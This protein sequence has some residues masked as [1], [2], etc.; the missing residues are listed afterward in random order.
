MKK[1]NHK[2]KPALSRRKQVQIVEV[3]LR[4]GLQNEATVVSVA[5]RVKLAAELTAAGVSRMELGA[6]VRSDR[7]PQMAGSLEVIQK[8]LAKMPADKVSGLAA[9]VPN[10]KGM[11]DAVKSGIREVSIFT[12]ASESFTKANTNCT[13]EESFAR[14]AD[15]MSEAKRNKMKVRGY[16]STCFACPYEGIIEIKKVVKLAERLFE[17]GCYEVSIGDTIGAATPGHVEKLFLALVKKLPAKSLAGHFHD[18]RGTA[19]A[20]ILMAYQTGI[21]IFDSSLG[22]IG[23]CPYA[24][25]AAGN[26]ATEDVVYMFEGMGIATGIDL[27]K[28]IEAHDYFEQVMGKKLPAK[29]S[30]AGIPKFMSKR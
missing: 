28:L 18:T 10:A 30:Q 3:A 1:M 23:G 15:V 12:A 2:A 5:N 21:S 8:T 16:L 25:G 13:I 20:N 19:L 7:V 22:G 29:M 26:V 6:F 14:F 9:L 24:P 27:R 17:L 11:A 4:D